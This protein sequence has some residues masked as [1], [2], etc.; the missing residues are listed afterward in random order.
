MT[1]SKRVTVVT[2]DN[3][4]FSIEQALAERSGVIRNILCDMNG[5]Q[6]DQDDDNS[7][8]KEIPLPEVNAQTLAAILRWCSHHKS[9][10]FPEYKDNEEIVGVALDKWDR[11]FLETLDQKL[12][13]D[14]VL[15]SDYLN[16]KPLL[17]SGCKVLGLLMKSKTPEQIRQ[18]FNIKKDLSAEQEA[19]IQKENEWAL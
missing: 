3:R 18:L 10:R 2:S 17:V 16:I 9:L 14:V 7:D 8:M 1:A 19:Q 6:D 4:R 13:Y 5:D 15:A 11:Q 12:L